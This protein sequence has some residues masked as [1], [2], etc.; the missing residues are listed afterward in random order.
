MKRRALFYPPFSKIIMAIGE[1]K[2]LDNLEKDSRALVNS[3]ES[4]LDGKEITILGP[5]PC[6]IPKI[7]GSHRWQI[8]LKIS[9]KENL[10]DVIG[11]MVK[12]IV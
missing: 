7:N 9:P 3:L 6:F 11:I 2:V 4:A 12:Y 5:S 1:D 8:L 10:E